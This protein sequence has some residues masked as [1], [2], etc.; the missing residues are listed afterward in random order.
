MPEYSVSWTI[1]VDADT[2]TLAAHAALAV[3][4]DPSSWATVFTV[5]TE[6]HDVVVD[7]GPT[8][9]ARPQRAAPEL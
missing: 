7:L 5:T 4:R 9:R 3:Q 2:P 1:D 6:D 8:P